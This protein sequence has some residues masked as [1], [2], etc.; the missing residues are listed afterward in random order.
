MESPAPLSSLACPL[1]KPC[2][3]AGVPPQGKAGMFLKTKASNIRG[4]QGPQGWGGVGRRKGWQ[5]GPR[6]GDSRGGVG[7]VGRKLPCG[8][9][10]LMD[11]VHQQRKLGDS[12]E[13]LGW[14]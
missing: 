11:G 4:F 7:E 1:E 9:V 12:G 8:R 2:E 5:L 10:L 3:G 6:G 13:P 14:L